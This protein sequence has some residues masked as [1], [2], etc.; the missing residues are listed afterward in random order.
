[1]ANAAYL[2]STLVMALLGVG[3][4]VLVLRGRRWE[5]YSPQA[6]YALDAGGGRP[7]S[8]LSRV[9]G[10][11]GTWTLGFFLIVGGFLAA[12]LVTVS[13]AIG[14]TGVVAGLVT[15]V[16]VYLVGGVYLALRGNGRPTSQA[17]AG[18]AITLGLLAVAAIGANLIL[19]L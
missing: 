6:A 7:R 1:M 8:A 3:V 2:A 18:S 19:G 11:T 12:V 17:V 14:G 15:A 5:H 9:A 16:V 4:V 10:S 13:G